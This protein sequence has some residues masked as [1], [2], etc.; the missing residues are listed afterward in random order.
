MSFLVIIPA[1]ENSVRI[2]GKNIIPIKKK[3][4]IYY[5]IR[6]AKKSKYIKRI[7]VSTDS[8][9]IKIISKKY[10]ALV[11]FLRKKSLAKKN[12]IMHSVVKN[13]CL[14]IKKTYKFKFK[15]IILLQPTSPLRKYH[16]INKAC[17]LILNNSDADCL[18]STCNFKKGDDKK[19]RMFSDNKY[20]SYFKSRTYNN[21]CLRNGPAIIITRI[22]NI[23]KFLIGGKILNFNMPIKRSIDINEV[24]DLKKLNSIIK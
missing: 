11:P 22:N 16:D 7:F 17:K 15:Y 6:E 19:K 9:K 1:R 14:M 21:P 2:K 23:S 12:S 24:K 13:F 3:P 18:V 4:L 20:L 8:Q 10:G 5:T